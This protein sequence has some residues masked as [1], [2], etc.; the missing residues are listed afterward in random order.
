M[1]DSRL[2]RWHAVVLNKDMT[3]LSELLA[4]DVEFHSPTVWK[5]KIGKDVTQYILQMIIDIFEDFEYQREWI[6][7]NNFALEFSAKVDGKNIKGI[8]LI[9]WN[10]EG[11]IIHFEVM[12]RPLN[13]LQLVLDKMT[14][15]LQ[16]AGFVP[17]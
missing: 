9:H 7:G 14:K 6:D 12:L 5:P 17:K 1:S 13:G 16:D 8:D 4:D 11:K 2:E 10:D 15:R 3:T